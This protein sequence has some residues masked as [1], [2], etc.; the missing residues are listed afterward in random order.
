MSV[1]NEKLMKL[2]S[3]IYLKKL[4]PVC[5]KRSVLISIVNNVSTINV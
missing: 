1:V 2:Y 3:R 5:D 4:I